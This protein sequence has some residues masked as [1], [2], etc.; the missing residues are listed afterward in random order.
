M[1]STLLELARGGHEELEVGV[2]RVVKLL[3]AE[4]K[5]HKQKLI[6]Q[7]S[8]RLCAACVRV[9]VRASRARVC[10]SVLPEHLACAYDAQ[11]PWLCA[12][13]RACMRCECTAPR[14]CVLS[15]RHG[16]CPRHPR[17]G[18]CCALR[19]VCFLRRRLRRTVL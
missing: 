11:C 1:A 4:T 6:Q 19:R 10:G 13:A 9:C 14:A 3:A 2:N 16:P 17:A 18:F 8:A 7:V 5:T 15:C 12:C